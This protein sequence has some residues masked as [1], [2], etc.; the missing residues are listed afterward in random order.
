MNCEESGLGKWT[1]GGVD[2]SPSDGGPHRERCTEVG[3]GLEEG[4]SQGVLDSTLD[5]FQT[6]RLVLTP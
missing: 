1:G 3:S 6:D 2:P 5:G 4:W